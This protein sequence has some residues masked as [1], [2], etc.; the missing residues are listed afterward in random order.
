MKRKKDNSPSVESSGTH[1]GRARLARKL[2]TFSTA[3]SLSRE[4]SLSCHWT[5]WQS[6]RCFILS[7]HLINFPMRSRHKDKLVKLGPGMI[8]SASPARSRA[9]SRHHEQSV[10]CRCADLHIHGAVIGMD[11]NLAPLPCRPWG[12]PQPGLEPRPPGTTSSLLCRT[13]S[14]QSIVHSI[15]SH[16]G[17]TYNLAAGHVLS[18]CFMP[19]F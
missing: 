15:Y 5:S 9:S 4:L 12:D 14:R 16:V 17:L 3:T 7:H 10:D 18:R 1:P 8:R 13:A 6:S 19:W 2:S 11:V